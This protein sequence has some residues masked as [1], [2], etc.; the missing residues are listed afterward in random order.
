MSGLSSASQP[1]DI[2]SLASGLDFVEGAA[3]AGTEILT[4]DGNAAGTLFTQAGGKAIAYVR[5]DRANG[6]LM[7]ENARV[8]VPQVTG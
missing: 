4:E 5:F 3:P 7:A 6:P 1:D 2:W 8:S